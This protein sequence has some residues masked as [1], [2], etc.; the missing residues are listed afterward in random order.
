MS[1]LRRD[2]CEDKGEAEC[3]EDYV[4][5]LGCLGDGDHFLGIGIVE[6]KGWVWVWEFLR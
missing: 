5:G 1:D 2:Y 6:W 4:E 3:V